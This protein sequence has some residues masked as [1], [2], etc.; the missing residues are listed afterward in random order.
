MTEFV[1]LIDP[2][3]NPEHTA[4]KGEFLAQIAHNALR[5]LLNDWNPNWPK[6]ILSRK[7][8]KL[9]F[10]YP[11]TISAIYK[12]LFVE[13][14]PLLLKA[15]RSQVQKVLNQYWK[16]L[17]GCTFDKQNQRI[18]F[19]ISNILSLYAMFEPNPN[20]KLKVPRLIGKSWMLVEYTIEPIGLTPTKGPVCG[21]IKESDRLYAYGLTLSK[22]NNE[23][24]KERDQENTSILLY[25]GTG[26]D[27]FRGLRIQNLNNFW[28]AKTPGEKLY[29][30]GKDRIEKWLEKQPLMVDIYGHSLGGSLAYLTSISNP[31]KVK[32]VVA[33]NP[34]GLFKTN[35]KIEHEEKGARKPEV[36]ILMQAYDQVRK[37][38]F[39]NEDWKL[40][41]YSP[42]ENNIGPDRPI[43]W[44]AAHLR[45]LAANKDVNYETR[46]PSKY[47]NSK[48]RKAGNFLIY[49]L[50]R[51]SKFYLG[52]GLSFFVLT[53][54]IEMIKKHKWELL[55]FI[56]LSLS[57]YFCSALSMVFTLPIIALIS[58]KIVAVLLVAL[59]V[60]S[61]LSHTYS[62][63]RLC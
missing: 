4:D 56:S 39:Y 10:K 49:R 9:L 59:A 58:T 23:E 53:P 5:I 43:R 18:S 38:G 25:P 6:A 28:P 26:W 8:A 16:R 32:K 41:K 15:L 61:V 34:P 20:E 55:C 7:F 44:G 33:L 36:H 17:E 22:I 57:L 31:K 50:G 21:Y 40:H 3:K 30:W 51:H 35:K 13:R 27:T 46:E 37:L 54:I 45:N 14:E 24:K 29:Q 60:T 47:N 11:K 62:F 52:T 19:V 42:L 48:Y 1:F 2:L 63:T 12:A